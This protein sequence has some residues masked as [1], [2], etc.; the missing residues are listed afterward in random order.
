M[1]IPRRLAPTIAFALVGIL[2]AAVIPGHLGAVKLAVFVAALL[3]LGAQ[4]AARARRP[5]PVRREVAT[6]VGVADGRVTLQLRAGV[7][8]EYPCDAALGLREGDVG[9]AA[10]RDERVVGFDRL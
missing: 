8:A 4:L 7:R 5:S 10:I 3:P 6:I 9:V 1:R 2:I